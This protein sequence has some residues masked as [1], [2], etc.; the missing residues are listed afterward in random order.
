MGGFKVVSE[1]SEEVAH[2]LKQLTT[3]FRL[4]SILRKPQ[5][6][7]RFDADFFSQGVGSAVRLSELHCLNYMLKA[8]KILMQ[9][10]R[11]PANNSAP[12]P[13]DSSVLLDLCNFAAK[14]LN[15]MVATSEQHTNDV[16]C[17]VLSIVS[18][19]AMRDKQILNLCLALSRFADSDSIT[20]DSKLIPFI[21]NF[22]FL[23]DRCDSRPREVDDLIG[24]LAKILQR[25]NVTTEKQ[26]SIL[27]TAENY[28]TEAE[29]P[30]PKLNSSHVICGLQHW[31]SQS[32]NIRRLVTVLLQGVC[33]QQRDHYNAEDIGRVLCG[34]RYLRETPP[35][36]TYEI[37]EIAE[38]NDFIQQMLLTPFAKLKFSNGSDVFCQFLCDGLVAFREDDRVFQ[39]TMEEFCKGLRE[40]V[41]RSFP[42][43][44]LI[45]VIGRVGQSSC[46]WIAPGCRD[47]LSICVRKIETTLA[48]PEPRSG[49]LITTDQVVELLHGLRCC[50]FKVP[51][52]EQLLNALRP[53]VPS[54]ESTT[55]FSLLDLTQIFRGISLLPVDI[56]VQENSVQIISLFF[57]WASRL[58]SMNL[59]FLSSFSVRSDAL[60]LILCLPRCLGVL[61]VQ[62]DHTRPYLVEFLQKTLSNFTIKVILHLEKG[63][64]SQ[65]LDAYSSL[66]RYIPS[67]DAQYSDFIDLVIMLCVRSLPCTDYSSILIEDAS[68]EHFDQCIA[69]KILLV[70]AAKGSSILPSAEP[71]FIFIFRVL[72]HKVHLLDEVGLTNCLEALRIIRGSGTMNRCRCCDVDSLYLN[73][74]DTS[75]QILGHKRSQDSMSATLLV[76]QGTVPIAENGTVIWTSS[77]ALVDVDCANLFFECTKAFILFNKA[78]TFSMSM[79]RTFRELGR[80]YKDVISNPVL[81]VPSDSTSHVLNI[82]Q[83][84]IENIAIDYAKEILFENN[85]AAFNSI[86]VRCITNGVYALLSIEISQSRR[87]LIDIAPPWEYNAPTA[88]S[89][90]CLREEHETQ[91]DEALHICRRYLS[92]DTRA[93]LAAGSTLSSTAEAVQFFA[94]QLYEELQNIFTSFQLL[95]HSNCA[96][97]Q[98]KSSYKAIIKIR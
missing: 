72:N 26:L 15:C 92:I 46:A 73:M 31:S 22:V 23:L 13:G 65:L 14:A 76:P 49:A 55:S 1:F 51:E 67:D 62:G 93:S 59:N 39:H 35:T 81:R 87:L 12:K 60:D 88:T 21:V 27:Q 53:H 4:P 89:V 30:K 90:T 36:Q 61:V 80:F 85:A 7:E 37:E 54:L 63:E 91:G 94:E 77:K 64:L 8:L 97:K 44:L 79:F 52:V 34:C 28:L 58:L 20:V 71:I 17:F 96:V 68:V 47:L 66:L 5:F 2:S 29:R 57:K 6:S 78:I 19:S 25:L 95:Q 45:F 50:C 32:P 41:N 82:I 86:E 98:H 83:E 74:L 40:H 69:A 18:G 3:R 48:E 11:T 16:I 43:K 42:L 38:Y 24:T 75:L 9:L 70:V 84:D 56:L 33:I 10:C